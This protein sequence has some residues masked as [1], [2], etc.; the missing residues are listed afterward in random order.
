MIEGP[1]YIV[2]ANYG[3]MAVETGSCAFDVVG[4]PVC[5]CVSGVISYE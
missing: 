3:I 5:V 4:I 2:P 1:V